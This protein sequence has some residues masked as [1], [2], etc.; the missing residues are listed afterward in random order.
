MKQ[1]PLSSSSPSP[2]S[3]ACPRFSCNCTWLARTNRKCL[4]LWFRA[5]CGTGRLLSYFGCGLRMVGLWRESCRSVS[6][7]SA[8]YLYCFLFFFSFFHVL[9][10]SAGMSFCSVWYF[11]LTFC[12][13]L[14]CFVLIWAFMYH[15]WIMTFERWQYSEVFALPHYCSLTWSNRNLSHIP[16]VILTMKNCDAW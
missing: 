1:P 10:S 5:S 15:P 4:F 6:R 13:Y 3:S 8:F 12:W 14:L 16:V 7:C 9:L 11:G 2:V